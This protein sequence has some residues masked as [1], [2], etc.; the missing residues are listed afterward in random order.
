MSLYSKENTGRTHRNFIYQVISP[1]HVALIGY[2]TGHYSRAGKIKKYATIKKFKWELTDSGQFIKIYDNIPN[3]LA[4]AI[5][6]EC[7]TEI[8]IKA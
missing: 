6:S 8:M 7:Y 4:E 1:T 5:D 2:D 3:Q